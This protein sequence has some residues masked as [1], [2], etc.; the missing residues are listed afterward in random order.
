MLFNGQ[1]SFHV[2]FIVCLRSAAEN[3]SFSFSFSDLHVCS[4]TAA[5][6]RINSAA[7]AQ[8][9]TPNL[10]FHHEEEMRSFVI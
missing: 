6:M 1:Q 7:D 3:D 2:Y 10:C 9:N 4:I 5:E 8:D